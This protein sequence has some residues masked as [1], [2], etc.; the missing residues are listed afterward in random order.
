MRK[1]G[2]PSTQCVHRLRPRRLTPYYQVKDIQLTTYDFRQNP[3]FGKIRS[4]HE[5]FDDA[6]KYLQRDGQFYDPNIK[7]S[8]LTGKKK[9]ITSLQVQKMIQPHLH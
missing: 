7:K 2:T 4:A 6:L 3:G 9:Y 8:F 5:L 1:N